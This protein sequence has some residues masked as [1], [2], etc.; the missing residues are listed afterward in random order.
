MIVLKVGGSAFSDKRTG[1]SFINIV[2][3]NLSK[4][5]PD[6]AR[7]IIVQGAGYQGHSIASKYRLSKLD[8]NQL[9][10]SILR[11]EVEHTTNSIAKALI[12]GGQSPLIMSAMQLFRIRGGKLEAEGL[13]ILKGYIDM[14]F[15]PIV[16]SDAPLD[17]RKGLSVLSGDD[18]A[19]V[20][21][22]RLHATKLIFGTD[23]DGIMDSSGGRI[24]RMRKR[25]ALKIG[26]I[27]KQGAIDVSG[28]MARKL[29]QIALVEP[30][31]KVLV[32]N[33]RR[34]GELG[35]ALRGEHVGTM[36]Y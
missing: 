18:M 4:E 27:K 5:L 13:D 20:L 21:A 34:P 25:D 10:W 26:V 24:I 7:A 14:G 3:K 6:N 36:L 12:D 23:V 9:Q 2:A 22:N 15:M 30:G 11:Y 28:G 31:I 8:N 19:R 35:K 17:D 32:I 29:E 33:L 1:K 16:H